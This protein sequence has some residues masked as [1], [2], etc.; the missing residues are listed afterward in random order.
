MAQGEGYTV[1][2]RPKLLKGKND[3]KLMT[4]GISNWAKRVFKLHVHIRNPGMVHVVWMFPGVL[5]TD[6]IVTGVKHV[7]INICSL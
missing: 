2:Q 6:N 1:A 7:V 3:Q 5:N 4:T